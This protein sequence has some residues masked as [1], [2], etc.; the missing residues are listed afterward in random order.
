MKKLSVAEYAKRTGV[1]ESTVRRH[2][3]TGKLHAIK[4]RFNNRDVYKIIVPDNL[5]ENHVEEGGR[6]EYSA[7]VHEAEIINESQQYAIMTM[8]QTSFDKL[9]QQITSLSDARAESMHES[10]KKCEGE[11]FELKA[12]YQKMNESYRAEREIIKDELMNE[13]I[14]AAQIEAETRIKDIRASELEAKTNELIRQLQKNKED[15][16]QQINR[17]SIEKI[18]LEEQ[19]KQLT[20]EFELQ[21]KQN[22][23]VEDKINQLLEENNNLKSDINELER[24]NEKHNKEIDAAILE[25]QKLEEDNHNLN[26]EWEEKTELVNSYKEE[27]EKLKTNLL[28][29]HQIEEEKLKLNQTIIEQNKAIEELQGLLNMKIRPWYSK[30]L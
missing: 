29:Y 28:S 25:S 14:K 6:T 7:P 22:Q 20:I 3:Y 9:I 13:K 4:E 17:L 21:K 26:K 10:L 15:F 23:K 18:H 19:L 27:I 1:N 5:N 11:Y 2:I 24:I 30:K 12:E 16:Q 8:E